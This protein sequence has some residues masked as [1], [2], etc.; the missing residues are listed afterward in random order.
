MFFKNRKSKLAGVDWLIAGLGNPGK[1]YDGT[2]HNVGFAALDAAAER[3]GIPVRRSRFDALCGEGTVGGHRLL[4]LK[5][6]TFMN[7]SGGSLMKATEYYNVPSGRVI[8]LCDDVE[9]VPGHLR[10]R[11]SGS[12]GGHNGLKSIITFIGQEFARI[13]IGVGKKPHP[14][15]DMVDWVLGRFTA[16]EKSA[17]EGRYADIAAAAR[18]LMD[19]KPDEAMAL[20]N[21]AGR[22]E[23]GGRGGR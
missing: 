5:P 14:N 4:L 12:A 16:A 7:L 13:R 22:P 11:L 6:Q 8:V 23:Q 15:Y 1:K 2:R 9:L 17:V 3:W 21:G 19:G 18:L 20:Y 10:I